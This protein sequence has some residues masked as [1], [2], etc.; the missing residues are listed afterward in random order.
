[1]AAGGAALPLR[2]PLTQLAG[3]EALTTD[4]RKGT[5]NVNGVSGMFLLGMLPF[6]RV[7][8]PFLHL[9]LGLAN[10]VLK[11]V[12]MDCRTL[13]G[14]VDDEKA[15]AALVAAAAE[16]GEVIEELVG[17][18]AEC[19]DSTVD[20]LEEVGEALKEALLAEAPAVALA[21]EA[22]EDSDSSLAQ[23]MVADWSGLVVA[24][25]QKEADLRANGEMEAKQKRET[26]VVIL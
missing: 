9:V 16:R 24:A 7:I 21:E 10:G 13:G 2:T 14:K 22:A 26:S 19:I 15:E 17:V 23:V 25:R 1:M 8:M 4:K 3:F 20:L 12:L 18:L 6:W 11:E 5:K